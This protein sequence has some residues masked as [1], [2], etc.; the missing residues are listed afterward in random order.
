MSLGMVIRWK[1]EFK[2][3]RNLSFRYYFQIFL[4]ALRLSFILFDTLCKIITNNHSTGFYLT[5]IAIAPLHLTGPVNNVDV[6][7]KPKFLF[8]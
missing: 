8:Q 2:T 7:A 5:I 1:S 3:I 4:N 6:I